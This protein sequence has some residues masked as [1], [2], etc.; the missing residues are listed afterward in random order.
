MTLLAFMPKFFQAKPILRLAFENK[1]AI[2]KPSNV[3]A[4]SLGDFMN[5]VKALKKLHVQI[6]LSG[7]EATGEWWPYAIRLESRLDSGSPAFFEQKGKVYIA[8][9]PSGQQMVFVNRRILSV[10]AEE[11]VRTILML[12][13]DAKISIRDLYGKSRDP[14]E[15]RMHMRP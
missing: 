5:L 12:F 13:P 10:Q 8:N 7:N 6:C 3:A 14:D 1:G 9:I 2:M 4:K 11:L 15:F